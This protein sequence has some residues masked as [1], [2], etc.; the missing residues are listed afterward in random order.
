MPSINHRRA[1][2][3]A[4]VS[5]LALISLLME[6]AAKSKPSH[7]AAANRARQSSGVGSFPSATGMRAPV[8]AGIPPRGST[9]GRLDCC[10]GWG[11][12]GAP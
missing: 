8:P 3:V 11:R 5:M 7:A 4:V 10:A 2:A 9:G 12:V 6:A 1:A